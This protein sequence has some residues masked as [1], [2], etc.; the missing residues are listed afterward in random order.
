MVEATGRERSHQLMPPLGFGEPEECL[1]FGLVAN[2]PASN[3]GKVRVVI[4]PDGFLVY[5]AEA[6]GR[7][8]SQPDLPTTRATK[9]ENVANAGARRLSRPS[10]CQAY[11]A[12]AAGRE[13]SHPITLTSKYKHTRLW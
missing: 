6:E 4:G 1:Q 12:E 10:G 3:K 9:T 2:K 8:R 5:L 13:L 7:E 11:F